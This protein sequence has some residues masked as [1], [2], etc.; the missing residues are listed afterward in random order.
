MSLYLNILE[1][2]FGVLGWLFG[3]RVLES[4]DSLVCWATLVVG[5]VDYFLDYL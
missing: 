2:L 4:V 1:L 3:V 5:V